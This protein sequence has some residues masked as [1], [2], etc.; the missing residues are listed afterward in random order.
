MHLFVS[1]ADKAE[2]KIKC[3]K[4]LWLVIVICAIF[5]HSLSRSPSI[6]LSLEGRMFH[7]VSMLETHLSVLSD[8]ICEEA[9]SSIRNENENE[10]KNV[11]YFSLTRSCRH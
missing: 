3:P 5:L 11:W 6:E 10:K 1:N 8:Y 9:R 4:L 7:K 2:L